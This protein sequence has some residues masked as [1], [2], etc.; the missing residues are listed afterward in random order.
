MP[1]H[2]HL[3]LEP[4]DQTGLTAALKH[5]HQRYTR[6][7]NA[8]E[9]W[10]G[11]LWQGRFASCAMDE[12]HALAANRYVELNPLR[13]QLCRNAADW[14]WSSAAYHLGAA[15]S[16]PLAS[17]QT[18][19]GRIADWQAYLAH[20]VDAAGEAQLGNFTTSGYPLGALHWVEAL[21][22]KLR[23]RPKPRPVGRPAD[24]ARTG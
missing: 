15:A 13:A 9:G 17:P 23:C 4:A 24:A 18:W 7:I 5:A 16:D 3:V 8:R 22:T 14:R 1:N 2:V 10:T 20:G 19:M 21:E 12:G 6:A 11:Y